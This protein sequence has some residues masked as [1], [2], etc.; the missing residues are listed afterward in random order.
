MGSLIS[1]YLGAVDIDRVG[2]DEVALTG[3]DAGALTPVMELGR[4]HA[5]FEEPVP[6][7]VLI[8]Q[9]RQA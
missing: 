8:A 1:N 6:G 9:P 5:E 3:G 7:A 4:G 2:L